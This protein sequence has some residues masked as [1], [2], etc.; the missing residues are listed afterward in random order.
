MQEKAQ[1]ALTYVKHYSR[2]DLFI[3]FTCNPKWTEITAELLPGQASSNRHDIVVR[4]F[5]QKVVKLIDLFTKYNIF[6][7]TRCDMYS[8]EWQRRGLPHAHILL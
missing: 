8:I 4:V 6:G 1:D 2:P 3:T 5:R 7:L